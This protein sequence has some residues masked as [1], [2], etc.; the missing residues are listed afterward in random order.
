MKKIFIIVLSIFMLSNAFSYDLTCY[1]TRYMGL[2][3]YKLSLTGVNTFIGDRSGDL[4]LIGSN[5]ENLYSS[6]VTVIPDYLEGHKLLNVETRDLSVYGYINRLENN[7]EI[8]ID[9]KS[10]H[11][12]SCEYER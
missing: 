11:V 1:M 8:E 7:G 3:T 4:L 10:Y 9:S 6:K 2:K 5:G 12:K